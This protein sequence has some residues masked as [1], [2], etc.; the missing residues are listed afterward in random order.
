MGVSGGGGVPLHAA[1]MDLGQGG[2]IS[3]RYYTVG[4]VR[5]LYVAGPVSRRRAPGSEA[6][7]PPSSQA[8]TLPDCMSS[9]APQ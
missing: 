8:L 5:V 4:G 1:Y 7:C 3:D 2:Y 9:E 6:R